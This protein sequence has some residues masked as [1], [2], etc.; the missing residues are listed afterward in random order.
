MTESLH[1]KSYKTFTDY[2]GVGAQAGGAKWSGLI[3]GD[4]TVSTTNL[5]ASSLEI[6]TASACWSGVREVGG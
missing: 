5:P 6:R 3:L 4:G 2:W 1:F